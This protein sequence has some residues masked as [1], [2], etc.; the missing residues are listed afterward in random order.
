MLDDI[1]AL[2][3]EPAENG[4]GVKKIGGDGNGTSDGTKPKA[5]VPTKKWNR[6][7]I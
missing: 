7:N 6:F 2:K 4:T 1:P 3:G 5:N